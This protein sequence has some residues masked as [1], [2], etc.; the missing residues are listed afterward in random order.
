MCS[1]LLVAAC[2]C[3]ELL[4]S[5]TS[6]RISVSCVWV[7]LI[8]MPQGLSLAHRARTSVRRAKQGAVDTFYPNS[9]PK[10]NVVLDDRFVQWRWVIPFF[11]PAVPESRATGH[12]KCCTAV[13]V[14]RLVSSECC[15]RKR[16]GSSCLAWYPLSD[17]SSFQLLRGIRCCWQTGLLRLESLPL[18][19]FQFC[20]SNLL[21]K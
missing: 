15:I 8:S 12:C 1:Q 21:H 20:V 19:C 13:V 9:E 18:D 3:C 10:P 6:P 16:A 7:K 14:C 5:N 17:V 11:T 4:P 2:S